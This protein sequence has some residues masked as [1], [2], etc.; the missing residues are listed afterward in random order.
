MDT[1]QTP[2]SGSATT[3]GRSDFRNSAVDTQRESGTHNAEQSRRGAQ[4]GI[5]NAVRNASAEAA[6]KLGD[7]SAEL[8]ERVS[9]RARDTTA[10]LDEEVR[11]SPMMALGMAFGLGVLLAGMFRRS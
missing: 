4:E 8:Y 10:R 7:R 9:E 11:K 1:T 5:G 2:K 6:R 3:N